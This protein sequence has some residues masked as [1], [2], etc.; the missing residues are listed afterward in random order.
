MTMDEGSYVGFYFLPADWLPI[1]ST[2]ESAAGWTAASYSPFVIF[3][4]FCNYYPQRTKFGPN[5]EIF[6]LALPFKTQS[7]ANM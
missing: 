2:P 4:S 7:R 6:P 3:L 1:L 5:L